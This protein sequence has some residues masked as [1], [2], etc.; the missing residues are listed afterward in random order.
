MVALSVYDSASPSVA[1]TRISSKVSPASGSS[2]PGAVQVPSPAAIVTSITG[3]V[4]KS[5]GI[6]GNRKTLCRKGFCA[7]RVA[8]FWRQ[9]GKQH[10]CGLGFIIFGRIDADKS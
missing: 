5:R 10:T 7:G 9:H 1:R 8:V 3:C 6:L 2:P 4:G